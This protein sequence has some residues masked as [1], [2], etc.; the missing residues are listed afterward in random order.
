MDDID[1]KLLNILQKSFPICKR[2]FLKIGEIL[3]LSEDEVIERI[4]KL[5]EKGIIR[6]IGANFDSKALG[7]KS[8]LVGMKVPENKIEEVVKIINTYKGVTHNYL[9]N[10]EY[11]VW[12]T[13]IAESEEAID[14]TIEEISK[15]TKIK[16]ILNLP[17]IKFYKVRAFFEL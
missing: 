10:N 2:P 16:D 15:K 17:A 4:K 12:F 14:K 13:L 8:T 6:K 5:K 1:R 3:S 11:N 7:F 9:R